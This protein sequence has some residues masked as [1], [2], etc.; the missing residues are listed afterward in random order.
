MK[1]LLQVF[2]KRSFIAG[3]IEELAHYWQNRV[4]DE[5]SQHSEATREG[6]TNWLLGSDKQRLENLNAKE[7]KIA[8]QAMEYRYR[9]L[10]QRYLGMSRERGY[11]N[12]ITRLGSLVT[13]RSKIQT[14]ISLSG[15]RQRRV[16]D[17]LQEILQE[18]LQSD[19][20]MVSQIAFISQLTQDSRLRNAL[21]FA[22]LE[23]YCMR[24]ISN[25]PL[26]AYRFVNYLKR[27]QRSGLT[28]L[29]GRD[30]VRLVAEEVFAEDGENQV[31]SVDQNAIFYYQEDY[32]Q[33]CIAG[34]AD[35]R[36]FDIPYISGSSIRGNLRTLIGTTSLK[37]FIKNDVINIFEKLKSTIFTSELLNTFSSRSLILQANPGM[38]KSTLGISMLSYVIFNDVF[39]EDKISQV[40]RHQKIF[41]NQLLS[42]FEPISYEAFNYAYISWNSLKHKQ[43]KLNNIDIF[44]FKHFQ[45]K[46]EDRLR[47]VQEVSSYIFEFTGHSHSWHLEIKTDEAKLLLSRCYLLDVSYNNRNNNLRLKQ[48]DTA[49]NSNVD[50]EQYD[51]NYSYYIELLKEYYDL[52]NATE[53]SEEQAERFSEI[54][55]IA[56][57]NEKLS[58]L[59][60]EID[61]FVMQELNF[62]D[63]K[64]L[65][66]HEKQKVSLLNWLKILADYLSNKSAKLNNFIGVN[67]TD[68]VIIKEGEN[69]DLLENTKSNDVFNLTPPDYIELLKEYYDLV[70]ATELSEE[71]AERFSEILEIAEQNEKLS[72]LFNE[73]D[74][75]VM[76]ELNLLDEKHLQVNEKQK[77]SLRELVEKQ[78]EI[79][80]YLE[81]AKD[82]LKDCQEYD[83]DNCDAGLKHIEDAIRGEKTDEL[84][85]YE[86]LV[87]DYSLRVELAS[88]LQDY[89]GQMEALNK[90]GTAY[91][92]MGEYQQA[93]QAYQKNLDLA[94]QFH[95]TEKEKQALSFLRNLHRIKEEADN[96]ENA[97][98][99]K[100]ASLEIRTRNHFPRL[101]T[102]VNHPVAWAKLVSERH[103]QKLYKIHRV[104]EAT[105]SEKIEY[106]AN[107]RCDENI[108]YDNNEQIVKNIQQLKP[109]SGEIV[110]MRFF[111]KLSWGEI[112]EI[113]SRREGKQIGAATARKRGERA[114]NELREIYF[115]KLSG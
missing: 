46:I 115:K 38:G 85:E 60:N 97:I 18:L 49:I 35:C 44:V 48:V 21:V 84:I 20:Y 92:S 27:T 107:L 45:P 54:L 4:A 101:G 47:C 40:N 81:L 29:P 32:L 64:H 56:E 23:E 55:E 28:Q 61:D 86:K 57:Q 93:I 76:Q 33:F 110:K 13:L 63:E 11:R 14:W 83:K 102:Q 79:D 22:S 91:F 100:E 66:V 67:N 31:S 39:N 24:P 41:L 75:F 82:E 112:A 69:I 95:D 74:D 10:C 51:S 77:E 104:S 114:L 96:I 105:E 70:N 109:L 94:R 9:L 98:A 62:L 3:N 78:L 26:L 43:Y 15:D 88:L 89:G 106:L 8:K 30:L 34:I 36:D 108:S 53:L 19:N 58:L 111:Q 12:L 59:F 113:L 73:I 80:N 90:L 103:I 68:F 50:K 99:S 7:L 71:Q 37:D 72:L 17:V 87:K 25:Q 1:T 42:Q 2:E 6:I 16:L 65:Q 5:C 52:V